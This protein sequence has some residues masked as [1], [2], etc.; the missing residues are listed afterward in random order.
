VRPAVSHPVPRLL[1]A[2]LPSQPRLAPVDRGVGARAAQP[3]VSQFL[4]ELMH[5][6]REILA[7]IIDGAAGRFDP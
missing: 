2:Y 5:P 1:P 3:D 7:E 4:D 6:L